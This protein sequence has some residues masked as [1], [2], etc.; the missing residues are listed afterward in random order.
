MAL[1][2]DYLI[3]YE[4]EIFII[5]ASEKEIRAALKVLKNIRA[6]R[7]E[8]VEQEKQSPQVQ[9]HESVYP[10]GEENQGR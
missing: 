6:W 3:N 7:C 2:S 8:E 5:K 1:K 10:D 4:G 9:R